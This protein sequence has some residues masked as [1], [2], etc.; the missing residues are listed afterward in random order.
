MTTHNNKNQK[1]K[2]HITRPQSFFSGGFAG[3]AAR[4]VTSP[5]N[6]IKTVFQVQRHPISTLS[7]GLIGEGGRV[8]YTGLISAFSGIYQREGLRAFWKGNGAACVL[9]FPYSA[10]KF[11]AFGSMRRV[12]ADE[13]GNI[14]SRNAL[15]A[16]SASGVVAAM[17]VYPLEVIKNRLIVQNAQVYSG[18]FR[19][20]VTMYRAE[21]L[22][23]MYRGSSLCIVGAIPYDG[24][25]FM[26]YEFLKRYGSHAESHN[27][28]VHFANGCTAATFAQLLAHPLDVSRKR[29]QVQSHTNNHLFKMEYAG[30]Y[31][32][33]TKI[34]RNE[35]LAGLYKGLLPSIVKVVPYYGITFALLE[36]L[37]WAFGAKSR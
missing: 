7:A 3:I 6:V 31:D 11:S 37:Y 22:R 29:L 12:L 1:Q 8:A 34:V 10:I 33:L 32:C 14:S 13:N 16:G 18:M 36:G 21:G 25:M 2:T 35:G 24:G 30:V 27:P 20:L 9:L 17:I 28:L 4:S 5:L 26:A 15:L 23:A 19:G